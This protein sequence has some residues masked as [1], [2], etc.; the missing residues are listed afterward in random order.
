MQ[1]KNKLNAN[2]PVIFG[3]SSTSL[4]AA[5][6]ELLQNFPIFGIIF[7]ARNIETKTQFRELVKEIKNYSKNPDII[8][9]IDEEGGRVS[10][11]NKIFTKLPAA[12]EIGALYEQDQKSGLDLLNSTYQEIADRLKFF[13]INMCYAPVCDLAYLETHEVIGDR[14]FS[15][16]AEIVIELC[17]YTC[18]ILLKNGIYPV[19]KHIPGH[20]LAQADSHLSLPVIKKNKEY[21]AENDFKIFKKLNNYPLAMT[22]HI[23]YQCLDEAMPVTLSSKAISYIRSEI[24]YNNLLMTDDMNMKAL[25]GD[26]AENSLAA[27]NSGCDIILHCNGDHNEMLAIATKSAKLKNFQN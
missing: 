21:L 19:L 4:T 1:L 22:A 26:V 7:F 12:R 6:K 10:R 2:L 3:L 23:L 13:S 5:E 15:A 11:L 14:T 16:R 9:S 27:L 17:R 8:L 25:S 18:D 20:G 24:G